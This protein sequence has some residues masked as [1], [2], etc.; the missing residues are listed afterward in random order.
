MKLRIALA[1]AAA[2]MSLNAIADHH[3][4]MSCEDVATKL[5][6]EVT[7]AGTERFADLAGSCLGVVDRDGALYMHTKMIVRKV[8]GNKVTLYIPANDSTMVVSP[9]SDA[10]VL[11][12][13]QKI[14]PRDLARGQ[15]LNL[16]VSVDK[17]TQPVIDEVLMPSTSDELVAA[18][19]EE[20]R[21]LPTTG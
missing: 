6:R 16:Y 19:A 7:E 15:E 20:V 1:T 10:R 11:I 4:T 18:P 9:D 3:Y 21:A 14:R 8:R 2:M 12:G 13:G 5:N 17:F